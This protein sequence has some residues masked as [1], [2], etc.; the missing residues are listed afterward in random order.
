MGLK[1][2]NIKATTRPAGALSVVTE[3]SI[4]TENKVIKANTAKTVESG[5]PWFHIPD[6]QPST[7]Q[8]PKNKYAALKAIIDTPP[9]NRAVITNHRGIG[10]QRRR[11]ML[12]FC[13]MVGNK[14]D[15]AINANTSPTVAV[16]IASAD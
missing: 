15:V 4:T 8:I 11:S 16:S 6:F 9:T 2:N 13:S 14:V 10:R 7:S 5:K 1:T 3:T 12:P